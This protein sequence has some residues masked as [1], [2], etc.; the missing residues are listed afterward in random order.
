MR[1]TYFDTEYYEWEDDSTIHFKESSIE[2]ILSCKNF[3]EEDRELFKKTQMQ[4]YDMFEAAGVFEDIVIPDSF[5]YCSKEQSEEIIRS[6]DDTLIVDVQDLETVPDEAVDYEYDIGIINN[7]IANLGKCMLIALPELQVKFRY[8]QLVDVPSNMWGAIKSTTLPIVIYEMMNMYPSLCELCLRLGKEVVVISSN[9]M[10]GGYHLLKQCSTRT[11]S[12]IRTNIDTF[13]CSIS[14]FEELL[15]LPPHLLVKY[16]TFVFLGAKSLRLLNTML[17]WDKDRKK[18]LYYYGIDEANI[19]TKYDMV[20]PV[21]PALVLYHHDDYQLRSYIREFDDVYNIE[22]RHVMSTDYVSRLLQVSGA[23]PTFVLE[24]IC[25]KIIP[26]IGYEK[27]YY[28]YP[29]NRGSNVKAG[30]WYIIPDVAQI[31]VMINT[32]PTNMRSFEVKPLLSIYSLVKFNRSNTR[33]ML[34]ATCIHTVR[35]RHVHVYDVVAVVSNTVGKVCTP[36]VVLPGYFDMNNLTDDVY[37]SSLVKSFGKFKVFEN[38]CLTL[39]DDT[40]VGQTPFDISRC[41]SGII[42]CGDKLGFV[43]VKGFT[44]RDGIVFKKPAVNK[45][46]PCGVVDGVYDLP[47]YDKKFSSLSILCV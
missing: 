33:V 9:D 12:R 4:C 29:W 8:S 45:L 24:Y 37:F 16:D 43:P 6:W 21:G 28:I 1:S 3:D 7:V 30:D 46:I 5:V 36:S 18:I 27:R 13:L 47:F 40:V 19:R 38:W 2:E 10:Y 32:R 26:I 39:C 14:G 25:G 44:V 35:A 11:S 20:K 31:S 17:L 34:S 42:V 23:L 15:T 22:L 41:V